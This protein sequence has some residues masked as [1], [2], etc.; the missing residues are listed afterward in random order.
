MTVGAIFNETFM[1][2]SIKITNANFGEMEATMI[3]TLDFFHQWYGEQAEFKAA[4][5]ENRDKLFLSQ[6]T[7]R[8]LRTGI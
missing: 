2:K 3:L 5:I 7:Y 4:A 6:I 1:N 8:N